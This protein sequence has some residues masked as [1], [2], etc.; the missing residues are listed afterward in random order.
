MIERNLSQ[1]LKKQA[2]KYPVVTL[3]GP[4]QSGKTTLCKEV[5]KEYEYKNLE[6]PEVLLKAESDPKSF[7]KTSKKGMIVDEFQR[8][9]KLASYIQVLVDENKQKGQFIL[10]GS[11]QLE[12]SQS[13]SQSLAGRTSV[14][15]LLPFSYKEIYG[16][17]KIDIDEVLYKGFLP[18][19]HDEKLDPTEAF[20]SYVNTYVERDVRQISEVHNLRSFNLFLKLCASQIGQI[21]NF[22]KMGNDIGVSYK[23]ITS[24]ISLLEASFL[25]F[26]L[27]PYYKNL[28]KR[29]VKSPKLYFHDVGLAAYFLGVKE[30]KHISALPNKGSLFENFIVADFYKRIYHRGEIPNLYFYRDSGGYEIDMVLDSPNGLD[31]FEIKMGAT[32]SHD[33]SKNLIYYSNLDPSVR[34]KAIIYSGETENSINNVQ[35]IAYNEM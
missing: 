29:L 5:F 16:D 19:I 9:P 11:Q 4:R 32:Y 35:L 26:I 8:F 17:R 27:N 30:I 10:S 15:K 1:I 20:A 33:F 6:D 23:T 22:S 14:L 28:K 2:G 31:L 18:R 3:T 21:V 12:L 24:W 7:L 34:K 25:V 13:V